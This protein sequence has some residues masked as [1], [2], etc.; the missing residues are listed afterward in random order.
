MPRGNPDIARHASEGG[1]AKARR[2]RLTLERVES[3][4]GSLES[5]EDAMR[6]LDRHVSF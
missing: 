6:R 2:T 3:E 1:R 5:V 4:L